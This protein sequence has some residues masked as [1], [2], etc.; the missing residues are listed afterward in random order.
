MKITR[1][2]QDTAEKLEQAVNDALAKGATGVVLDLRNNPGGLLDSATEVA[3][4][5][6]D[7]GKMGSNKL[8]VYLVPPPATILFAKHNNLCIGQAASL[9]QG[10][11]YL[12]NCYNILLI[13]YQISH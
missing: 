6:L 12:D 5:F 1:F 11:Y 7:P 9:N 8:I 13:P 4:D 10:Y 3:D 2:A